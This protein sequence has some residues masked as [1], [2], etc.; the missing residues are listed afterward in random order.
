MSHNFDKHV[1]IFKEDNGVFEICTCILT[2]MF[3]VS[4]LQERV[5]E[6]D[7]DFYA[8]NGLIL[9]SRKRYTKMNDFIKD[10]ISSKYNHLPMITMHL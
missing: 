2:S 1:Y 9:D 5:G 10:S 8:V 7:A 6:F 4:Y 3:N